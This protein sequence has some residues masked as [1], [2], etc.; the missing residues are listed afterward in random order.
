MNKLKY[1][2][3]FVCI[4]ICSLLFSGCIAGK[5][6]VINIR[7]ELRELRKEME[8]FKR[9]NANLLMDIESQNIY[10]QQ[11]GGKVDES[12]YKFSEMTLR[13]ESLTEISKRLSSIEDKLFKLWTSTTPIASALPE[14]IYDMARKDYVRGNYDLA[15]LGFKR[16]LNEYSDSALVPLA[17][18]ELALTFYTTS[19]WEK[20]VQECEVFISL[21]TDHELMPKV[22]L[23]N[24][25]TAKKIGEHVKA[26]NIFEQV[27]KNYENKEEAKSAKE[28]LEY[29]NVVK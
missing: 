13:K 2:F 12:S 19:D 15:I 20:V 21:Y 1:L 25:R 8:H 9:M 10:L 5:Q 24:G 3:L 4:I 7:L 26:K 6:D 18:Y 29:F 28:E 16:I 14:D 11:I 17:Q 23:L 27:I 22:L